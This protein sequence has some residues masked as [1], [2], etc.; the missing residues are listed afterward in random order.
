M[1]V[2][3]GDGTLL[4]SA[5]GAT[6]NYASFIAGRFGGAS[7]VVGY[8]QKGLCGWACDRLVAVCVATGLGKGYVVP[9]PLAWEDKLIVAHEK[10]T[11]LYAFGPGGVADPRPLA[12]TKQLS[13]TMG[14]PTL[15]R[16]WLLGHD[17]RGLVALSLKDDLASCWKGPRDHR[18][19]GL[20]HLVAQDDG[21][22]AVAFCQ[23]GWGC[24]WTSPARSPSSSRMPD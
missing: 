16:A 17:N 19:K 9:T 18:Q 22:R 8:D 13:P 15:T 11:E 21:K 10:G 24:W 5:Q 7:Q 20:T 23:S 1:A 4:W 6:A 12:R 2:D 3:P 14:T